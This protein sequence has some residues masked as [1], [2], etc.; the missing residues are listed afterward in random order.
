MSGKLLDHNAVSGI[1][2]EQVE[3]HL[4]PSI[5]KSL[6]NITNTI[7]NAMPIPQ[8][9][10]Q[11]KNITEATQALDAYKLETSEIVFNTLRAHFIEQLTSIPS[12]LALNKVS[13]R[14]IAYD[15][16]PEPTATEVTES[17][18]WN[19]EIKAHSAELPRDKHMPLS[20]ARQIIKDRVTDAQITEVL[21]HADT[22]MKPKEIRAA[23]IG[24][25]EQIIQVII[26][27]NPTVPQKQQ[28]PP[29]PD[30]ADIA[31]EEQEQRE[32]QQRAVRR[33]YEQGYTVEYI[34]KDLDITVDEVNEHL[35]D[36]TRTAPVKLTDIQTQIIENEKTL[37]TEAEEIATSYHLRPEAVTQALNGA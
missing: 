15:A 12:T 37:G 22:G 14:V 13:E 33:I 24:L 5:H 2:N 25:N 6:L 3:S 17:S 23:G 29:E 35:P 26:N 28:C 19:E 30:M 16:P 21:K 20:T 11:G 31:L 10:I 34:A 36:D 1:I 4:V 8:E 7:V 27:D 18:Q 32:Y 9:I